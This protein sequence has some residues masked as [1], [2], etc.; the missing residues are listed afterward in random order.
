MVNQT[1]TLPAA[2]TRRQSAGFHRSGEPVTSG[3]GHV[4][5]TY[6]AN[7]RLKPGESR[8]VL[9]GS[10]NSPLPPK[11]FSVEV[12]PMKMPA[13]AVSSHISTEGSMLRYDYILDITNMSDRA[14]NAQVWQM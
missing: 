9:I 8:Q 11:G 2:S 10:S 7:I 13:G 1:A 4:F 6:V 14:I 5:N 3:P 12:K